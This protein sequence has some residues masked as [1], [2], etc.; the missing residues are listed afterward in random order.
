M[1]SAS[2]L[3]HTA[4]ASASIGKA[5]P[6]GASQ[7][8]SSYSPGKALFDVSTYGGINYLVNGAISVALA[9]YA[10]EKVGSLLNRGFEGTT[11][12]VEKGLSGFKDATWAAEKA[13]TVSKFTWLGSG[14]FIVLLPIK[15]IEDRKPELV[16]QADK[17]F[18]SYPSSPK[19][20]ATYEASI[21]AEPPQS[22]LSLLGG[23]I[24]SLVG[25]VAIA[26]ATSKWTA[27]W[28]K[29]AEQVMTPLFEKASQN[30][31][32][33]SKV[34]E[35]TSEELWSCLVGTGLLYGS[36]KAIASYN[37]YYKDGR[38]AAKGRELER[39]EQNMRAEETPSAHNVNVSELV[40]KLEQPHER[41]A[42][43][44]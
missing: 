25:V 23:R 17:M 13:E 8:L 12:F 6:S 35:I 28:I 31:A 34:S 7:Y 2:N 14:G 29:K 5:T 43:L 39:I 37:H 21:E 9:Y 16:R 1:T 19:D 3:N 18:G 36:S 33:A 26:S 24:V 40:G 44:V 4:Q 30:T 32:V 20:R 11:R 10:R 15:W 38:E 41:A 27:P 22:A 42:A